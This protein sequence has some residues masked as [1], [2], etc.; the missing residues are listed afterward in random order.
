MNAYQIHL[1]MIAEKHPQKMFN[2]PITRVS[3][4][5]TNLHNWLFPMHLSKYQRFKETINP[6]NLENPIS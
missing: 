6:S 4:I 3:G 1:N 5:E 2:V